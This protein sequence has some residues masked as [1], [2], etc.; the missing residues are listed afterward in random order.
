[1]AEEY[2]LLYLYCQAYYMASGVAHSEW[3]SV[4]MHAI[5]R[6]VNVLH[7]GHLIP[8]LSLSVGGNIELASSWVS[9]LYTLIRISLQV[10]D[11]NEESVRTAF[12]WLDAEADDQATDDDA[13]T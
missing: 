4:E 13:T 2:G 8:S 6:C 3:R 5:E 9:Q 1:M 10:L 7:G 11:T 12:A